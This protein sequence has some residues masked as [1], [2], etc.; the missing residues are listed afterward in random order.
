MENSGFKHLAPPKGATELPHYISH[1]L[2]PTSLQEISCPRTQNP[3]LTKWGPY[4]NIYIRVIDNV[5]FIFIF[6]FRFL[7][8]S[9]SS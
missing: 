4:I 7:V 6:I 3:K 1:D 8:D 9:T 5:F 2:I